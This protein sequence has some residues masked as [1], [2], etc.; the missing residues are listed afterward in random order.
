MQNEDIK[1]R[2]FECNLASVL[3]RAKGKVNVFGWENKKICSKSALLEFP[4]LAIIGANTTFMES[5]I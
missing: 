1:F 4:C 5:G 3:K 2:Q